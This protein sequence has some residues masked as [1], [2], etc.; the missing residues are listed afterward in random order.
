MIMALLGLAFPFVKGLLGD[1]LVEKVLNH[2]KEL[3]AS[4]NEKE[5]MNI[6]ADIKVIEFELKR[7]EYIRDLRLKEYEHPFLW[8][9]TYIL[10]MSVAMYWA[11][12]FQVKTWGLDDFAIE[13]K[14]LSTEEAVVS[15]MI[16]AFWY[17]AG[18]LKRIIRK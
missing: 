6:D 4:A 11:T 18:E 12:R 16:L 15:G 7:R 13:I 1:G 17:G 14:D 3:A 2:K 5:R 9:P 10:N 8:M